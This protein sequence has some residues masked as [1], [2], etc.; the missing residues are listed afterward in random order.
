MKVLL[1]SSIYPTPEAPL[2]VGG[3]EIF[4]RR[5][6]ESLRENGDSV[7]VIRAASKPD[8][9]QEECNGINVY[10]APVQNIYPP[11]TEQRNAGMR[12]IWHAIEDWQ[13][14]APMVSERIRTFKPDVLHSNNLSGL[15]T[16]IWKAAAEHGVP[17]VH[18][19]HDY[20]LVCPRCSRFSKGHVCER[21]CLSCGILTINRKRASHW[22]S[23]VVG[24]SRRILD[25]HVALG[26]FTD[27]PVRTVIRNA[28]TATLEPHPR[29]C[30]DTEV[31]FGFIGRLT[32][33]KG[34]DNLVQAVADVPRE[35]VRLLIAGRASDTEQQRLKAMAPDARIEFLGFIA[36][37]DFYRQI[38]V[39]VAP[40]IWD[41]PGP[42]V[43]ADASAAGKPILGTHFGGMPEVIEHGK[44]GWITAADPKSLAKSILE[45]AANP[46]Q[47]SDISY[48]LAN[49]TNKWTFSD[50]VAEYRKL[51]ERLPNRGAAP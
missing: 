12:G 1:T 29:I 30:S 14:T 50:V 20:Y 34:V 8:Q 39:V 36:P 2:L 23:A 16:A 46:Q 18:T 6:A 5:F 25:I 27:V 26:L 3:A 7:E 40:S 38:D 42:L 44:T 45:I 47:I 17:V 9:P 37:D 51:F 21:T 31:T 49:S 11:F 13:H 48:R 19:L 32:E 41:D 28:S 35:K 15:T 33:E 10:S 24:V 4:A 22:L 43:V